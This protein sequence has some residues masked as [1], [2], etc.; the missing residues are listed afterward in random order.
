MNAPRTKEFPLLAGI[1]CPRAPRAVP[2]DRVPRL[3]A[4][5]RDFL[6]EK[7]CASGG[8]LGLILGMLELTLALHRVF[9]SPRDRAAR[10]SWAVSGTV[11]VSPA[12]VTVTWTA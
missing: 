1:S 10:M 3:A 4:Q 6:V 2:A 7:V 9:D 8:H 11:Q 5:I 12:T